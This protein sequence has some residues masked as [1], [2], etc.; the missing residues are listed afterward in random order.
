M[1]HPP[2]ITSVRSLS[3]TVPLVINSLHNGAHKINVMITK[4]NSYGTF[5][6]NPA[7]L[8]RGKGLVAVGWNPYQVEGFLGTDKRNSARIKLVFCKWRPNFHMVLSNCLMV[9]IMVL[10]SPTSW[11]L[12]DTLYYIRGCWYPNMILFCRSELWILMAHSQTLTLLVFPGRSHINPSAW[13]SALIVLP[14]YSSHKNL[15][16]Q[17]QPDWNYTS[18]K[19][20][21]LLGFSCSILLPSHAQWFHPKH[22]FITT[23]IRIPFLDSASRGHS[24]KTFFKQ[25]IEDQLLGHQ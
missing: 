3:T 6:T 24:L 22:S 8:P 4:Y 17:F 12:P 10:P 15:S 11:L 19:S 14:S 7:G 25:T 21:F 16:S 18:H 5:D 20:I 1:W 13:W 23:F 2:L 9:F